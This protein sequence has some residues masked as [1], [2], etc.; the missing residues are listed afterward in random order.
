MMIAFYEL[1]RFTEALLFEI[2]LHSYVG[3]FQYFSR[4]MRFLVSYALLRAHMNIIER[5]YAM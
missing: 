3:F 5:T 2:T 4:P 1:E